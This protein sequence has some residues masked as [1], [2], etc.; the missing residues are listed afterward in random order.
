MTIVNDINQKQ[1]EQG[2]IELLKAADAAYRYARRAD[3]ARTAVTL[4]SVGSAMFA[5][6]RTEFLEAQ[7]VAGVV[8]TVVNELIRQYLT[9]RWT[10]KG[11]LFQEWFDTRLY[12]LT[13]SQ[14]LDRR[15]RE[16]DRRYWEKRFNGDSKG[17]EDWY[18]D[19]QG[20]PRG[21]AI[22][23][24]QRENLTWDARLRRI[25]GSTL[26]ILT[27]SWI[28]LGVVV[29]LIGDWKIWELFV[30][31]LAP[32]APAIVF[33]VV[34]GVRHRDVAREK[35]ALADRIEDL[36]ETV[37]A[38]S[39]QGQKRITSVARDIQDHVARLRATETRVPGWFYY[40]LKSSY[41]D[42]ARTAAQRWRDKLLREVREEKKGPEEG[43]ERA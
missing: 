37:P 8:G 9:L 39:A 21:H 33:A 7:V 22:L 32:S 25:W 42:E 23:L 41:E 24:C 36:L 30:R 2:S 14:D 6:V 27:I 34:S 35:D 40:R 38:R 43:T 29:G 16:E 5:A 31:W 10:R 26:L 18:I 28:G 4:L 17:K 12:G 19:V 13:W 11:M 15:P 3:L 20:L 1:N